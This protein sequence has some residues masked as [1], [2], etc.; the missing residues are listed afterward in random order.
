MRRAAGSGT[1]YANM[2]AGLSVLAPEFNPMNVA[3]TGFGA[4]NR[5]SQ[6][7]ALNQTYAPMLQG[8]RS[9]MAEQARIM[10]VPAQAPVGIG[11]LPAGYDQAYVDQLIREAAQQ[12]GGTLS[13][14]DAS[15][16][17]G[18]LGIP[19]S[20]LTSP[21]ITRPPVTTTTKPPVTTTTSP[22]MPA[23]YD[24]AYVDQLIKEAAQQAGGTLSFADAANAAKNLGIPASML[25]SPL[26]TGAPTSAASAS[27]P[28]RNTVVQGAY[29]PNST[30]AAL[31]ASHIAGGVQLIPGAPG[32]NPV[33]AATRLAE[34]STYGGSAGSS[35]GDTL[36]ANNLYDTGMSQWQTELNN[37]HQQDVGAGRVPVGT[38]PPVAAAPTTPQM[39]ASFD[40]SYVNQLIQQAAQQAGGT[41]SFADA[42]NAARNLG[43]PVSMLTSPLITGA[44][45][46]L[47]MGGIA[48][49]GQGGY[50]RRT[51]QISGPGTE[52]SDSI[53]AMLSDG[54][55]V[56]TAKAV[57]GA[58]KGN[59]RAGAK[60][61]Y[62]LMH[63][64]EKN[65]ERG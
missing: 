7:A 42:S 12:A 62:K 54:E 44:P 33:T 16:A 23:T 14:A 13:F 46:L 32:Y 17:A 15:S 34:I 11:A 19:N 1:M 36:R 60:Q 28:A 25:T 58:G 20:M 9:A 48:S 59:R 3:D 18:R 40:Q 65:S 4:R 51:G 24:Q 53:P 50:P 55:F 41:L 21:L 29:G 6:L 26:I 38:P 61:M 8:Q 30:A 37:L 39:P 63:Q 5:A 10:G 56:M 43:I 45:R 31:G 47:N 2:N 27:A 49:L 22:K 57:R 52:K 64:L 35:A